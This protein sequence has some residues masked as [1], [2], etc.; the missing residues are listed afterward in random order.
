MQTAGASRN[1]SGVRRAGLGVWVEW[2]Q[3]MRG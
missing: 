3:A 2:L 1:K